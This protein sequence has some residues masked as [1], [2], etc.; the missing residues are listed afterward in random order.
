MRG[1]HNKNQNCPDA[2]ALGDILAEYICDKEYLIYNKMYFH[3]LKPTHLAI[4][5]SKSTIKTSK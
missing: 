5:S 3:I 2:D 4:T 1:G